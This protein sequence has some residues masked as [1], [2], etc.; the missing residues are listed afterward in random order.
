MRFI[1]RYIPAAMTAVFLM[2]VGVRALAAQ[3]TTGEL[4]GRVT[5]AA[6]AVVPGV[7]VALRGQ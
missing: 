1:T 2:T 6:G 3:A 7:T 5:D 4:T